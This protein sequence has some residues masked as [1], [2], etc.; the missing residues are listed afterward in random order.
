MFWLKNLLYKIFGGRRKGDYASH[1]WK[2]FKSSPPIE[3]IYENETEGD[4]ESIY[5]IEDSI[6]AEVYDSWYIPMNRYPER[7]EGAPQP[8]EV[9]RLPRH[10]ID[11][12]Q[13]V[14]EAKSEAA[15]ST[16]NNHSVWI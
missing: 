2:F 14:Y 16:L 4:Y 7:M 1:E 9:G 15:T 13:W 8:L 11:V 5:S 10:L 6:Y 3:D 12:R